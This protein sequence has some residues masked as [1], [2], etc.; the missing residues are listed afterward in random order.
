MRYR[1]LLF[2]SLP[3]LLQWGMTEEIPSVVDHYDS[4]A[5]HYLFINE[6]SSFYYSE[7]VYDWAVRNN[8]PML[9]A[10]VLLLKAES[11]LY[12][13]D[14]DAVMNICETVRKISQVHADRHLLAESELLRGRAYL[15]LDMYDKSYNCFLNALHFSQKVEDS[16]L[17]AR[18]YNSF[19]ILSDLQ[20]ENE[21]S[22]S[23]Y[24]LALESAPDVPDDILRVRIKNNQAL[25]YTKQGQF[26][27]ARDLLSECICYIE[28]KHLAFA[29]DRL[30]MNLA[31][32]YAV[33]GDFDSAMSLIDNALSIAVKNQNL[34]SQ[35]R[36]L[37]YKGYIW[38]TVQNYDSAYLAFRKA[39]I[40]AREKGFSNLQGMIFQYQSW[41]AEKQGD[42]QTAY[43]R[44]LEYK[45]I[46]DSL[47]KKR[48]ITNLVRM[49]YEHER[50]REEM[51]GKFENYRIGLMI[52]LSVLISSLLAFL[53]VWFYRKQHRRLIHAEKDNLLLTSVLEQENKKNVTQSLYHQKQD[54]DLSEI[55]ED[56]RVIIRE[57]RLRG[58][59]AD[60]MERIAS[61]LQSY[62][63][64]NDFDDFEARFERVHKSFFKNLT[65]SYP[66]LSVYERRL[67]A[68][69]R[70]DMNSKEIASLTHVS[71]RSVEQ[72]RYRL[73]KHLGL[74]RSEE[75][76]S[77]LARFDE[78]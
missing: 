14:V 23:Y 52:S 45:L 41:I 61:R 48:N 18:I 66:E 25:I 46:S 2:L 8:D 29:L 39:E 69:L 12:K 67:C 32:L 26:D 78:G 24:R 73:R 58:T 44:L 31:P 27:R 64:E 62:R 13:G 1:L 5:R 28:E 42:Y 30:Y 6:D 57:N 20:G 56:I 36:I 51:M 38:Y 37:I 68:Y 21:K 4:L 55:I 70:L 76:S 7:R 10:S 43:T 15:D 71:V 35:A 74:S 77:F 11:L 53:L 19:G 17:T 9:E 72:A 63:Q 40:I 34:S 33:E 59:V 75:L 49:E 50:S 16:S 3:F 54:G 47:E 22:L 60:S 65:S